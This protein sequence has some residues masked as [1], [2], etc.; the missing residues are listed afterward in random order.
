MNTVK[1]FQKKKE[2]FTCEV[3][4]THVVGTG[5]TN[6]CN[7]CFTSKHVDIFPGDRL[8]DCGGLM[9]VSEIIRKGDGYILVHT[10]NICHYIHRDHFR[11]DTDNI[12]GLI[13]LSKTL[14]KKR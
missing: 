2:N 6:H 11:D 5:Y 10:C 13:A 7:N 4:S 14:A 9:P 12:D 1:R 8:N 3:C